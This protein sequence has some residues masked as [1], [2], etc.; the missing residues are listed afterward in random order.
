M[1]ARLV[2][3]CAEVTRSLGWEEPIGEMELLYKTLAEEKRRP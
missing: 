3:G 2:A 1:H